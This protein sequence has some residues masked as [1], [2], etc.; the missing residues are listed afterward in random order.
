MGDNLHPVEHQPI[1]LQPPSTNELH[2]EARH[3]VW[4]TGISNKIKQDN[5]WKW[6]TVGYTYGNSGTDT[7]RQ[8]LILTIASLPIQILAESVDA[9]V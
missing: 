4:Q 5:G 6:Q 2:S 3:E 7:M 9:I 1:A 8:R